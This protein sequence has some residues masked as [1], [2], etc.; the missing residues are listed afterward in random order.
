[1][2]RFDK[3]ERR[4]AQ[5]ELVAVQQRDFTANNPVVF[6]PL[7]SFPARRCGEIYRIRQFV[8]G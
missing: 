1:M 3:H 6:Q 4:Q 7:D 2:L 5:P 8:E